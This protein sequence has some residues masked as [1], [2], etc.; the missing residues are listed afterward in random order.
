M[1][2][3]STANN[4]TDY[5]NKT[6]IVHTRLYLSGHGCGHNPPW[7]V[8]NKTIEIGFLPGWRGSHSGVGGRE[9][10]EFLSGPVLQVLGY[11]GRLSVYQLPTGFLFLSP[12]R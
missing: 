1:G 10:I 2:F 5:L 4:N 12:F 11:S 6:Y 8:I 9:S 7:V 3:R